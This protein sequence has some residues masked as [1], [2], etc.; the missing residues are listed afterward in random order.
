MTHSGPNKLGIIDENEVQ[1]S[2]IFVFG[3]CFALLLLDFLLLHRKP[4][5]PTR[6]PRL[7]L[8]PRTHLLTVELGKQMVKFRVVLGI[9]ELQPFLRAR[10]QD[11]FRFWVGS[12]AGKIDALRRSPATTSAINL[13]HASLQDIARTMSF[14]TCSDAKRKAERGSNGFDSTA[15]YRF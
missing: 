3:L 7:D 4:H 10:Q 6:D 2:A 13:R 8:L 11:L 1:L 15:P 12:G 5:W 9:G 14:D